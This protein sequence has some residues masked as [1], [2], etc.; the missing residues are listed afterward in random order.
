M[1]SSRQAVTAPKAPKA[2]GNYSH[3]VRT[4]NTLHVSGWMGNDPKTGEIVDGGIQ[5]QTVCN[6]QDFLNKKH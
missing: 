2:N 3:A 5:P 6:D 4:G 1:S